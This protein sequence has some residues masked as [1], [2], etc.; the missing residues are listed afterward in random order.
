MSD[1]QPK[2][3]Y[4]NMEQFMRLAIEFEAESAAFYR[5]MQGPELQPEVRELL[6]LLESQEREHES[7]L[8]NYDVDPR[9]PVM[10]QFAPE[11]SLS[12]PSPPENPDFADMLRLAIAREEKSARIYRI[13]AE[14]TVAGFRELLE[15]LAGF[16]EEHERRLRGLKKSQ[17]L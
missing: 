15:G 16:E 3:T 11:L 9:D 13:A 5:S 10:I 4:L 17:G 8:R 7:I 1:F 12:M 6:Q 14:M 2:K